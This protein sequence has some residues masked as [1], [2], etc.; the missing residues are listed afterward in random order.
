MSMSRI[1]L[2]CTLVASGWTAAAAVSDLAGVIPWTLFWG[3][4]HT[5]TVRNY[6]RTSCI[7][8]S[9]S[10]WSLR[11]QLWDIKSGTSCKTGRRGC[12]LPLTCT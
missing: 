11:L 8:L 4:T 6:K 1:F 10:I 12:P 7:A 5:S 9:V 2:D 3:G